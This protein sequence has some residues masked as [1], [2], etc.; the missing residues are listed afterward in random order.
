LINVKRAKLAEAEV[1]KARLEAALERLSAL[2]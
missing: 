2:A 1:G